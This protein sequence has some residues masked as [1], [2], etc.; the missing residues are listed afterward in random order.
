MPRTSGLQAPIMELT[1]M[2]CCM[3]SLCVWL[4]LTA[5][6]TF[7]GGFCNTIRSCRAIDREW[8]NGPINTYI[9]L[10][11][12]ALLMT[13]GVLMKCYGEH[14]VSAKIMASSLGTKA[15]YSI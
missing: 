12:T 9:P 8:L 7:R 5:C 3:Y 13:N 6:R 10:L 14:T 2:S 4:G 15:Q 1:G 11:F